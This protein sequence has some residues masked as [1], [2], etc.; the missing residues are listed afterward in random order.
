MKEIVPE[1]LFEEYTRGIGYTWTLKSPNKDDIEVWRE[2]NGSICIRQEN[3]GQ[4]DLL[5]VN[6]G[7]AY[8]LL[9]AL[10]RALEV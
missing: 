8:D 10:S 5:N 9:K 4:V 2:A 6:C 1:R 3:N 7:Q